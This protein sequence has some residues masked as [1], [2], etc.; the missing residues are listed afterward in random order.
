MTSLG[1]LQIVVFFGLILALTKPVG[2]YMARVF[3]GDR[4]FL[5]PIVRPLERL[6]YTL[7]GIR[8]DDEQKWTQYAA[9]LLSFSFFGFLFTYALIRLQG[10]LP[11]NPQGFG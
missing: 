9:S 11:L 2:L 8:E 5:H 7:C 10:L 4:T 3:Q 6:V 1:V